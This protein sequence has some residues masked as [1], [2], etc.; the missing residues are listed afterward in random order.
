M[1]LS[2]KKKIDGY[3]KAAQKLPST[4]EEYLKFDRSRSYSFTRDAENL[5][6]EYEQFLALTLNGYAAQ[7][8]AMAT[9]SER[10]PEEVVATVYNISYVD[11]NGQTITENYIFG[12][13]PIRVIE[14]SNDNEKNILNYNIVSKE[15]ENTPQTDE[16]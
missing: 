15:E 13:N 16:K 2:I 1:Q 14:K 11:N 3:L 12:T 8:P 6:A 4:H 10:N 5:Q 7:H 9:L